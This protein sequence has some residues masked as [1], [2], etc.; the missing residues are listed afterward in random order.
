MIHR[1]GTAAIA[2]AAILALVGCSNP[3]GSSSSTKSTTSTSSYSGSTVPTKVSVKTPKSLNSSTSTT[4]NVVKARGGVSSAQSEGYNEITSMTGMMK[5]MMPM[6][7][8]FGMIV[9]QAINNNGITPG[10][11]KTTSTT[12]TFTQ[13]MYNAMAAQV[14][15]D[16]TTSASGEIGSTMT[17]SEVNYYAKGTGATPNSVKIAVDMSSAGSGTGGTS[18]NPTITYSWSDDKKS[19]KI[20]MDMS[21]MTMTIAYDDTDQSGAFKMD[22]GQGDTFQMSLDPDSTSSTNGASA[23]LTVSTSSM[24]TFSIYGYADDNGGIVTTTITPATNSGMSTMYWE[25]GFDNTGTLVY[26]ASSSTDTAALASATA[27][28][29]STST[30]LT[31]TS[32]KSAYSTKAS[33]ATTITCGATS[34]L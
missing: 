20:V 34:L 10:T 13:E 32:C 23:N 4:A 22:D 24:G 15:S 16:D 9:D 33:A 11:D 25:E 18:T 14:P 3:A 21:G 30:T 19:V 8:M 31:E 7:V 6:A 28:Y 27:S 5:S 26:Q 12:V 17:L 29:T 2:A 1:L